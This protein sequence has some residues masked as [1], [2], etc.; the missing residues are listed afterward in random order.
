MVSIN[1]QN[2]LDEVRKGQIDIEHLVEEIKEENGW[3]ENLVFEGAQV[4]DAINVAR[5]MIIKGGKVAVDIDFY[6]S[7]KIAVGE[8]ETTNTEERKDK[9][10]LIFTSTLYEED[11]EDLTI[12]DIIEVIKNGLGSDCE[13]AT[14]E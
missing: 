11:L 1:Y 8:A 3:D 13:W 9:E 2:F 14:I 10:G 7:G 4:E 6:D 12:Y 5:E